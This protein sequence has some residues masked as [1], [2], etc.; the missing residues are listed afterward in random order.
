MVS[1]TA[2]LNYLRSAVVLLVQKL[3]SAN[4]YNNQLFIFRRFQVKLFVW[5]KDSIEPTFYVK[6][7]PNFSL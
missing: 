2:Q 5:D 6:F 1:Q 3:D 4:F 7:C